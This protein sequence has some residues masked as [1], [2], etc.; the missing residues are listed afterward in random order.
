MEPDHPVEEIKFQKVTS[1]SSSGFNTISASAIA[2]GKESV[3]CVDP[4]AKKTCKPRSIVFSVEEKTKFEDD[5]V[6]SKQS[7]V[8][9][10]YFDPRLRRVMVPMTMSGQAE[11]RTQQRSV[12]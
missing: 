10:R 6:Q 7:M 8:F 5:L 11:L 12:L 3:D 2:D 1:C 9:L 4:L